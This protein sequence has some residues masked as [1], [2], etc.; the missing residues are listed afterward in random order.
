MFFQGL[1]L[2][3]F[4]FGAAAI[5]AVARNLRSIVTTSSDKARATM[6][7]KEAETVAEAGSWGLLLPMLD[8]RVAMVKEVQTL[9][10]TEK[11][12]IEDATSAAT[13]EDEDDTADADA[14]ERE[15]DD[16]TGNQDWLNN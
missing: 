3:P 6:T 8:S 7:M 2:Q 4:V 11:G 9:K 13:G 14:E 1:L 15:G 10:T 16:D 5:D 12:V